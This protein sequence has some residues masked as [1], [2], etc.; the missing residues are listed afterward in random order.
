MKRFL[1]FVGSNY[2]P[3]GGIDDFL[4][5]FD[6]IED[7]QAAIPRAKADWWQCLDTLTG[8]A[9]TDWEWD[10]RPDSKVKVID[11]VTGACTFKG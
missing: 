5:S 6:T 9:T 11:L 1:V 10:G 8:E 3:A 7:A 4:G 2:Y